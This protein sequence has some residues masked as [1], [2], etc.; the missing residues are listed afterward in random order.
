MDMCLYL[1]GIYLLY[2]LG[3][4]KILQAMGSQRVRHARATELIGVHLWPYDNCLTFWAILRLFSKA[5]T[6]SPTVYE[7]STFLH[8]LTN[9]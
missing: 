1:L 2:L 5:T 9:T 6:F 8:I 7:G 4:L 3:M